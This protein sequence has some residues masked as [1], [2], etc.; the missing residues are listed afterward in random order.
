MTE[1]ILQMGMQMLSG[2]GGDV[3]AADGATRDVE[4]PEGLQKGDE[5]QQAAESEHFKGTGKRRALMIGCNYIGSKAALKGCINDVVNLKKLLMETWGWSEDDITTMTDTDTGSRKPTKDNILAAAKKLVGGAEEGDY[6]FFSFSGHGGQQKDPEGLESDGMNETLLPLD[7]QKCGMIADNELNKILVQS[8]PSG[9]RLTAFID[10][11]HSGT[12]LDLPYKIKDGAW[13]QEINPLF[14]KGDVQMISGCQDHA[15]SADAMIA[16]V[17]GGALT[18]SILKVLADHPT[19]TYHELL[20]YIHEDLKSGNY[21]Q[22]PVMTSSQA[23]NFGRDFCLDDIMHNKNEKEGRI[24][25]QKFEPKENPQ[26]ANFMKMLGVKGF[27]PNMA[28]KMATMFCGKK[29]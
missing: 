17:A 9:C 22:V 16:G 25:N 18:N 4:N 19:P 24:V 15:T 7:F 13:E 14:T 12:G 23:F 3:G 2:S 6:L 20:K 1:Q 10:A 11:C 5:A 21:K 29:N 27:N 28:V 26:I 8:L